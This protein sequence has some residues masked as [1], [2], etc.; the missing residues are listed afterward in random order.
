MDTGLDGQD[1]GARG[2][3]RFQC[4]VGV[5]GILG[6]K[7]LIDLNAHLSRSHHI[8][9]LV[10]GLGIKRFLHFPLTIEA[11]LSIKGKAFTGTASR[12]NDCSCYDDGDR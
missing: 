5:S 9:Q 3:A 1:S 8:E 2:G 10:R 7:A 11:H 12:S 4:L 6:R